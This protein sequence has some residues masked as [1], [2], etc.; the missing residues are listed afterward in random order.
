MKIQDKPGQSGKIIMFDGPDG[1]GKTT[2]LTDVAARLKNAGREVYTTRVHGGTP[3]GEKL[4][5]VSLSDTPRSAY[6]DLFI[7]RAMHAELA[8]DLQSRRARG[9]LCLVDRSPASMW[10]YQVRAGGL[11]ADYALPFIKEDFEM[12]NADLVL[13]YLASSALLKQRIAGRSRSTDY[14]ENKPDDFIEATLLGYQESEQLFG[15]KVIEASGSL[16]AVADQTAEALSS[17][18]TF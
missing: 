12:F 6:T 4:R 13:V 1:V 10:A 15:T 9:A 11:P 7:S 3:I 14:F 5:E 18:V 16:P 17:Y 8:G 2:M